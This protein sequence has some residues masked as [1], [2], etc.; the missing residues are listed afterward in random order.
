MT[1]FRLPRRMLVLATSLAIVL[2]FL[3]G[4]KLVIDPLARRFSPR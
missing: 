4:E 3:I 1:H 2:F